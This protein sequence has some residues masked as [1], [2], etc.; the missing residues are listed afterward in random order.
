MVEE[1]VRQPER[2]VEAV[3]K[4]SSLARLPMPA[5]ERAKLIARTEGLGAVVQRTW[6]RLFGSDSRYV[7][8]RA[9]SPISQPVAPVLQHHGILV[10]PMEERDLGDPVL[11]RYEPKEMDRLCEALVATQN[12]RIV[13]AAWYADAVT[14]EQ[15]WYQIVEPF[16]EWP[17]WFGASI[18]VAPDAKGAG[19]ALT[20]YANMRVAAAGV[21]SLVALVSPDNRPSILRMRLQGGRVVGRLTTRRWFGRVTTFVEPV[22][23]SDAGIRG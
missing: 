9:V 3:T 4:R 6:H 13:G 14:P 19:W 7:F 1:L 23:D 5:L 20:Q 16:L 17:A 22:T 11:R 2:D 12:G 18:F 15:P 10:R 21:R 8:V